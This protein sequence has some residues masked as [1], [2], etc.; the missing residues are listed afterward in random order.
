MGGNLNLTT[1]NAGGGAIYAWTGPNGFTSASQ[2]PVINNVNAKG[3]GF[4]SKEKEFDYNSNDVF[5]FI[6]Y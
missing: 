5:I 3:I 1:G 2:N 4:V 6:Y